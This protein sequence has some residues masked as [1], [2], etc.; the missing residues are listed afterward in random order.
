[1]GKTYK[2]SCHTICGESVE[3][4]A[5]ISPE[6]ICFYMMNYEKGIINEDNHALAG[7]SIKD[8]ILVL[9]SG[10]GSSVLQDEGL[11]A[12]KKYKSGPKGIVVQSS[13]TV[14]IAAAI[15]MDIPLFDRVD[16]GFY[17]IVEN[18][19]EIRVDAGLQTLFINKC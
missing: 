11:Y 4:E 9:P 1:M 10:K 7:Q 2:F 12:L 16:H 18:G 13:D 19:D 14:L 8:K 17:D 5:L 3:G 15:V 6:A